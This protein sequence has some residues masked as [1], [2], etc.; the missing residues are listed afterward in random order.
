MSWVKF[1]VATSLYCL[2]LYWVGSWWGLLVLPFIYDLY[3]SRRI[4]WGWWREPEVGPVTRFLMSWVDAIVFAL[5][6]IYFLNQF[7]FRTL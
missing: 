4:K 6:A 5:V 3:I 1:G 2:F 7:F